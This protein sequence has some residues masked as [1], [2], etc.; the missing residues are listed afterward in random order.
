MDEFNQ[1][2]QATA[3]DANVEGM[4]F[5]S[6]MAELQGIVSDLEGNSLE[7]EE[8]LQKYERGVKLLSYLK[9]SLNNAQQKI[10]TLMGEFDANVDDSVTDSTLSKA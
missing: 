6:A 10:D 1:Q 5:R 3:A 8:S 4:S 2:S 7:L 9:T